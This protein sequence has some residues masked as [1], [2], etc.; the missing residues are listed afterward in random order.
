[1]LAQLHLS[2][3]SA[4]VI[5]LRKKGKPLITFCG[6]GACKKFFSAKHSTRYH[7]E[8]PYHLLSLRYIQWLIFYKRVG[9]KIATRWLFL[10]MK[11]KN[12]SV[13]MFVCRMQEPV[14]T[15][16]AMIPSPTL[17]TRTTGSTAM[18]PDVQVG[19]Q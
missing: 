5:C 15:S 18:A 14:M 13:Q 8:P 11:K 7:V 2:L 12:E 3:T 9:P 10:T 4:S 19:L 6:A 1:M 16:A 17:V